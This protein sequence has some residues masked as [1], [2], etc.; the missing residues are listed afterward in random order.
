[1]CLDTARCYFGVQSYPILYNMAIP[2]NNDLYHLNPVRI[3]D[4]CYPSSAVSE[5]I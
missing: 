1:M 4:K 5:Y 3:P 2:I